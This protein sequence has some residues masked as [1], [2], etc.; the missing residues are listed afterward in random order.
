MNWKGQELKTIGD[1]MDKGINQCETQEEA[2]EFMV[3]YRA[4]NEHADVNIGYL[5]GYYSPEKA[6]KIREWFGVS[7]PIFGNS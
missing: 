5:S 1:L 6:Q 3:Q 4:E 2:Q 7:H